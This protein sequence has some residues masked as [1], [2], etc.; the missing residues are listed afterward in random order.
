VR[1]AIRLAFAV[2]RL[3]LRL[4]LAAV[5]LVSVAALG[6]AWQTRVVR[7]EQLQ[8]LA[9]AA[10]VV[11]GSQ[12]S[13]CPEQ[14]EPL[15]ALDQAAG[16]VKV[17]ILLTPIVVGLFLGVPLVARELESRTAALAWSLGRSRRRWLLQ[18]GAPILCVVVV[19]SVAAGVAGD[20]LVHAAPWVEGSDPGFSDWFA[21]GPQL[22]VRGLAVGAVG[23]VVGT[24]V[25]RQLAAVLL[26][27]IATLALFVG[28]TLVSENLMAGAAEPIAIQPDQI[29]SGKIYGSGFREDAT[30]TVLTDEEAYAKL[31]SALDYGIP[32]GY[33][34]VY[35][36]V[37]SRR[38]GEFVLYE[39][40]MF[41][42]VAVIGVAVAARVVN[43]RRP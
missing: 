21:R 24:V 42:M 30:G 14:D 39:A 34:L 28:V 2:H 40:A 6:I 32:D 29:V 19:A 5:L 12:G 18:R 38:Y 8:C 33:S 15:Q 3:E 17:A 25:G 35:D 20:L 31:G 23:L 36:M 4:L 41:G 11:A 22:A 1:S 13:P 10:P 16:F 26:A 43:E 37:P 9:A 27:A 7:E